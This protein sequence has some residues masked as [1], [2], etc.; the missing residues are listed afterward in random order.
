MH[1]TINIKTCNPQPG[2]IGE[3]GLSISNNI[4]IAHD[5]MIE[6]ITHDI[7]AK[8]IAKCQPHTCKGAD[9]QTDRRTDSQTTLLCRFHIKH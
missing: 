2:V 5:E 8:I 6:I 1:T 9:L 3:T 4:T 7:F